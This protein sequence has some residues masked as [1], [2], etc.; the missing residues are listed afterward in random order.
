[1]KHI[2]V[3]YTGF[4]G[5][6]IMANHNFDGL[7]NSSNIQ[8]SYGLNPELCVYS[9]VRAEMFLA[10]NDPE[11][12]FKL[13]EEAI[14]N[15]KKINSKKIVLISTVAVYDETNKVDE[16]SVIDEDKCM[17]YGKNR[18]FLEN[19]VRQ[20]CKDYLIIRL[21]AIYGENLKKNFIYDMINISPAL[22]KREKFEELCKLDDFI[23]DYYI[24]LDNGF[25]KC[26]DLKKVKKYFLNIGFSALNF[27][28]S[29]S[30]YQFYNL[31][32]LWN[33]IE[34]SI[35]KNLRTVNL[36]TEPLSAAELYEYIFNGE[37][38]NEILENPFRY[39]IRSK[40]FSGGYI[41]NKN[42]VLKDIK[43]F[44]E[45]RI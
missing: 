41:K 28:D 20:N 7:Y 21:P 40:Y 5:S 18:L 35:T 24:E 39:D 4:V 31:K 32:N 23:K 37:F 1:M 34:F 9:A 19:W 45:K 17:P 38:K 13:I 11:L 27:T 43:E 14:E 16:D 30:I 36:V 12:D 10:N 44:I 3:G 2:L 26:K 8:D 6:N 25:Y 29:R 42:A 33:D 15:I 22:L